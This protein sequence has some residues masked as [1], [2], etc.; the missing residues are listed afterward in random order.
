[1]LPRYTTKRL[2]T[3]TFATPEKFSSLAARCLPALIA[4]SAIKLA[5]HFPH[6]PKLANPGGDSKRCRRAILIL[7]SGATSYDAT[8][9]YGCREVKRAPPSPDHLPDWSAV[10]WL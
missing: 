1:M 2:Q 4:N 9:L 3:S 8:A 5:S 10:R 6:A 7:A